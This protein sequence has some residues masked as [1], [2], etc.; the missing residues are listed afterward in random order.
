MIHNNQE[1]TFAG[2]CIRCGSCMSVCPIYQVSLDET[3]VARGKMALFE[4]EQDHP[5]IKKSSRFKQ[6]ISRCLLCGACA[7]ICPNKVPTNDCIQTVRQNLALNVK[8]KLVMSSINTFSQQTR[9]AKLFRKS[10]SILQKFVGKSIPEQSGLLLRFPLTSLSSR[11]YIPKIHPV[12]FSI[13]YQFEPQYPPKIL[14]F[15][16][17][18]ANYVFHSTAIALTEILKKNNHTPFVPENQVCCGLPFYAAGDNQKATM[19]AKINIDMIETISPDIILTTCASCGAQIHQW[20]KLLKGDPDYELQAIKIADMQKD[21]TAF[22]MENNF[23]MN[24]FSPKKNTIKENIWY[25]HPCHMR[26]GETQLTVPK[27]LFSLFN[28]TNVIYSNNQCCGN[29]GKFQISHFDLSMKIFDERMDSFKQQNIDRVMTSCTGCHFQF[30]E[31]LFQ[32]KISVPVM[33]P[34]DWSVRVGPKHFS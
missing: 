10:S 4:W 13:E 5:E 31:G 16:G 6:S 8:E 32:K 24:M 28:Q 19:L 23:L 20:K 12:P 1:Q 7:Q 25:H 22:I 11:K 2:K 26:W 27:E 9:A 21:A 29:G 30:L 18:G 15:T 34:L 14:Y 17:C 3:D 33:H